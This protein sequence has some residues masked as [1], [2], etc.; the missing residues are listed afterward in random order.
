MNA[1]LLRLLD[2]NANR[3]REAL[4]VLE[5]YTRFVLDD[6][7]LSR[8]LKELRHDLTLATRDWLSD[9]ILHRDTP[10]DVG[11]TIKTDAEQDRSSLDDV[12]TA[13]GKRLGEALRSL[14]EFSKI[15]GDGRPIES[16][17]YRFY[18]IEQAIA[19]TISRTRHS[20]NRFETVR[21]YVLITESACKNNWLKTAEAAVAGG[22]DA[23]QLREK[24]LE[25]GEFLRRAKL[26]SSLCRKNNLLLII[27]DRPDIALLSNADG[28]HVGQGDLSAIDARKIVGSQMIVGVSTHDLPQAKKAVLDGADYIGIGPIFRSST[29]PRDWAEIPGLKFAGQ[30]A[31]NIKI[32]AVAIAGINLENL[33][34]VLATG[35]NRI[36]VTAAVTGCDDVE[37][38]TRALKEKLK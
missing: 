20:A 35:I 7:S 4:R 13:A 22:A 32:P 36:A 23:L 34:Q 21:L 10:G 27:N 16:I 1:K 12:I 26:L 6:E 29:K 38:V 25:S 15:A 33:E 19:R 31:A 11:T 14:E 37:K 8:R 24:N 28:V 5:D 17:R 18:D 9:A 2:A 3:A 30:A